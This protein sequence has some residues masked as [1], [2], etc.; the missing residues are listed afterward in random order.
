[1]WNIGSIKPLNNSY[2]FLCILTCLCLV[3]FPSNTNAQNNGPSM[4]VSETELL[5]GTTFIVEIRLPFNQNLNS[6]DIPII[7]S[8]DFLSERR[9]SQTSIINSRRFQEYYYAFQFRALEEEGEIVVGPLTVSYGGQDYVFEEKVI[10]VKSKEEFGIQ[11]FELPEWGNISHPISDD[12]SSLRS[13]VGTYFS[14]LEVPDKI[15]EGQVFPAITYFFK[16]NE[17]TIQWPSAGDMY[18]KSQ[19]DFIQVE[20][21]SVRNTQN[22][23]QYAGENNEFI[24]VPAYGEFVY[25]IKSGKMTV[26]GVSIPIGESSRRFFRFNKLFDLQAPSREIEVLPLPDPGVNVNSRF[27]GDTVYIAENFQADDVEVG[28]LVELNIMLSGTAYLKPVS[29]NVPEDIPGL[30]HVSTNSNFEKRSQGEYPIRTEKS[31]KIQYQVLEPGTIE[32]PSMEFAIFNPDT[33]EYSFK[34]TKAYTIEAA[35]SKVEVESLTASADDPN[36]LPQNEEP[37]PEVEKATT[38]PPVGLEE[39]QSAKQKPFKLA[40]ENKV[41]YYTANTVAVSMSAMWFLFFGFIKPSQ[42]YQNRNK[43]ALKIKEIE[44]EFDQ[45]KAAAKNENLDEFYQKTDSFL[46]LFFDHKYGINI[47]SYEEIDLKQKLDELVGDEQAA[48]VVQFR[49]ELETYRYAPDA[50]Q[51]NLENHLDVLQTFLDSIITEEKS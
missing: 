4:T 42:W 29:L 11:E 2:I 1:M 48:R 31:F 25:P 27:V 19:S 32:I 3:T 51:E 21:F 41:V 40:G 14:A 24:G 18:N 33:E 38:L 39:Y 28:D 49:S 30:L 43:K 46:Y 20:E 5:I 45:A 50:S 12:I 23:H 9:G 22:Q 44:H 34:S 10:Q 8:A 17:D 16:K 6:S 37:L 13:F 35:G 47:R 15:Y 7:G 36:D 26:E